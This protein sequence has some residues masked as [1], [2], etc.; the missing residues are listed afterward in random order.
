MG[1]PFDL[2]I[3]VCYALVDCLWMHVDDIWWDVVQEQFPCH[4]FRSGSSPSYVARSWILQ[5]LG[6]C[7]SPLSEGFWAEGVIHFFMTVS[8]IC[9]GVNRFPVCSFLLDVGEFAAVCGSCSGISKLPADCSTTFGAW[10]C[11]ATF[12]VWFTCF[13]VSSAVANHFT[14]HGVWSPSVWMSPSGWLSP[15]YIHCD[16]H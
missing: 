4:L 6:V 10:Y 2:P 9:S 7:Y 3:L 8:D 11:P 16:T 13:V 5:L 14:F 12:Q 1:R 15:L